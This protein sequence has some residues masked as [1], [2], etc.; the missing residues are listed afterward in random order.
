MK[1]RLY[2][3]KLEFPKFSGELKQAFQLVFNP[4]EKQTQNVIFLLL[5]QL[6]MSYR[7]APLSI[8]WSTSYL[9]LDLSLSFPSS[10][11]DYNTNLKCFQILC[12]I[13]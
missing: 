6:V 3:E 8:F 9:S 7:S 11:I 2:I 10:L 13:L 5:E 12:C 4:L 1:I